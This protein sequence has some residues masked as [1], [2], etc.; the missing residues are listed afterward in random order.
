MLV[1]HSIFH[2]AWPTLTRKNQ[3]DFILKLHAQ[4]L[5][6][7][8]SSR[9]KAHYF[10]NNTHVNPFHKR[11]AIH[12]LLTESPS[13]AQP[14]VAQSRWSSITKHTRP[15]GLRL[16]DH[17]LFRFG[18]DRPLGLFS[19]AYLRVSEDMVQSPFF[20]PS[21]NET[22][23][24]GLGGGSGDNGPAGLAERRTT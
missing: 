24:F 2:V 9:P 15:L 10:H 8:M 21:G 11:S 7:S 20:W 22:L 4:S 5:R 13:Q 14:T 18:P 3:W 1:Y 19:Q 6:R 12:P 16:L 17:N 23:D